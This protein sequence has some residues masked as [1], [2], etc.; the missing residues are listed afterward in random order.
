MSLRLTIIRT[1]TMVLA[2]TL[3]IGSVLTYWAAMRKVETEIDAAMTIAEKTVRQAVKEIAHADDARLELV[4][5]VRVFDG[6]RHVRASFT[7]ANEGGERISSF[8]APAEELPDW[9]FNLL[10]TPPKVVRVTLP[11]DLGQ[12]GTIELEADQRGEV[13]EVWDDR[14]A[15]AHDPHGF[16]RAGVVARLFHAGTGARALGAAYGRVRARRRGRL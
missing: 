4:R 16:L 6:N 11:D 14:R 2:V 15:E 7:D 12:H 10:A 8:V 3:V 5:L 1:I 13:A 9:F